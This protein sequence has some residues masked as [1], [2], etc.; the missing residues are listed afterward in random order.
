MTYDELLKELYLSMKIVNPLL[1]KRSVFSSDVCSR[2]DKILGSPSKKMALVHI[3]GT[4][5]KG[6]VAYKIAEAARL[7]NLKVGLFT[8]PHVHSFKERIQ[9]N[10]TNISESDFANYGKKVV[11]A[12]KE[13]DDQPMYFEYLLCIAFCY[14]AQKNVDIAIVETGVGGRVD[15]TNF[16][17]PILSV[18]TSIAED[19]IPFLGET[20]E[21]IA[22]EKAGI[23]KE[24]TPVV[25]GPSAQMHPIIN[26]AKQKNAPLIFSMM[27]GGFFDDENMDIAAVALKELSRHF[28]IT[29]SHICHA[30]RSRP[31]GRFEVIP[32]FLGKRSGFAEFPEFLVLDAA[33]NI[34][35]L[36]RL[37]EAVKLKLP[38]KKLRFVIALSEHKDITKYLSCLKNHAEHIYLPESKHFK[39]L[40]SSEL[41][42]S[43][44]ELSYTQYSFGESVK[45]TLERAIKKTA[46]QDEILILCGSFYII[47]DAREFLSLE[48]KGD[49]ILTKESLASLNKAF[50]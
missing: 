30:V 23:I 49:E 20:I 13:L 46:A 14:F 32:S 5:G 41:A 33:H 40:S 19:H 4:N 36:E 12:V 50:L 38:S 27:S 47:G 43:L 28:P 1:T 10:G 44:E 31:S 2:M 17:S 45:G 21:E 29:D 15:T 39:L 6:S 48:D 7:A 3:A 37:I 24:N 42:S 34:D 25:L 9:I 18:I 22:V 35:A 16:I 11:D 8:S 26:V